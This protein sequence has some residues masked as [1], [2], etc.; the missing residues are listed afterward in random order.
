[1]KQIQNFNSISLQLYM[2]GQNQTQG[3]RVCILNTTII[4]TTIHLCLNDRIH[5]RK[6]PIIA[7]LSS[8]PDNED[9]NEWCRITRVS[10]PKSNQPETAN[11]NVYHC[12]VFI[13]AG[14]PSVCRILIS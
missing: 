11:S 3:H 5:R 7:C 8:D 12:S 9:I 10:T 2:P 6:V 13:Y 14:R 4:V 1:M